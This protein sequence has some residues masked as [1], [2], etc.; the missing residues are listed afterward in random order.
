MIEALDF[1]GIRVDKATQLTVDFVGKWA[2]GTRTCA[3]Q[4]G[5]NNFYIPGEIVGGDTFGSLYIGRGRTPH[6]NGNRTFMEAVTAQPNQTEMFMR[7]EGLTGYGEQDA[8][9][10]VRHCRADRSRSFFLLAVDS[11]AFHYSFYRSLTRVLQLDGNLDV[12][13]DIDEDFTIVCLSPCPFGDVIQL[14]LL[15]LSC[16]PGTRSTSTRT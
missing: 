13:D 16:R 2:N 7:E 5:K 9:C 15:D 6:Q 10:L 14:T 3:R 4:H 12:A 8:R 1:D 11:T